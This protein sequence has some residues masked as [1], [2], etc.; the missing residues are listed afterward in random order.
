METGEPL[1]LR[2]VPGDDD[3]GGAAGEPVDGAVVERNPCLS[4][5]SLEI[6]LEPHLPANRVLVIGGSPIA[7]A[8]VRRSPAPPAMTPSW[9]G[10]RRRRR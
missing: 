1:L 8:L 10:R 6:F 3:G 5:G 2:L 4:G 9:V 7:R